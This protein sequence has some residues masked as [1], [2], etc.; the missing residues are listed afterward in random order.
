MLPN[1]ASAEGPDI[2]GS[3]WADFNRDGDFDDGEAAATG[4]PYL[5]PSDITITAYDADGNEA[6]GV[7]EAGEPPT[8]SIDVSDLVGTEFVG[9]AMTSGGNG[10]NVIAE[11]ERAAKQNDFV[12]WYNSNR[13]Y[14]TCEVTPEKWTSFFRCTPFVDKPNAP[15]E[16]KGTFVVEAGRAGAHS[17]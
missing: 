3:I 6:S 15:I 10:G 17:A 2:T 1:Q 9:T 7:I 11:Y 14:V 8:Y 16:T 12:K 5:P 13:G 4:S